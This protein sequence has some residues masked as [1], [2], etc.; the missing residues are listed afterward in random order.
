MLLFTYENIKIILR[1]NFLLKN[2]SIS[3]CGFKAV[4]LEVSSLEKEILLCNPN[5]NY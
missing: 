2:K 5:F 1:S 4:M 3:L